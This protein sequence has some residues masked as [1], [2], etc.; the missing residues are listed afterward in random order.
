MGIGSEREGGGRR[1]RSHRRAGD[2]IPRH[3]PV[4][5][6]TTSG[7]GS[8]H[9]PPPRSRPSLKARPSD[10]RRAPKGATNISSTDA[11]AAAKRSAI[12]RSA[13]IDDPRRPRLQAG[14]RRLS[15]DGHHAFGGPASDLQPLSRQISIGDFRRR[16]RPGVFVIREQ[17]QWRSSP[18][19]SASRQY[20]IYSD[21]ASKMA[22]AASLKIKLLST[23]DT[24]YFYVS[25]KKRPD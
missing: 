21:N 4:M 1:D 10:G 20:R 3:R 15:P 8:L 22:K 24:G 13:T 11:R 19:W 23:A 9:Q 14:L 7:A 6:S 5:R 12:G 17:K 25:K 16:I 2:P 18:P